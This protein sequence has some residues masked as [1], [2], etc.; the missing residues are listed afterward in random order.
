MPEGTVNSQIV[1]SV[2]NVVTLTGGTAPAQAFAMLDTVMIETLGMAMYNA[3]SRQQ[4]ASMIGSAAVTAACAKMLGTPFG[5]PPPAPPPPE[6]PAPHGVQPLPPRPKSAAEKI[7]EATADA[8]DALKRILE[9]EAAARSNVAAV[10]GA[11][12]QFVEDAG[13]TPTPT[14]A[15]VPPAP[16]PAPAPTPAPAPAPAPAPPPASTLQASPAAEAVAPPS[17]TTTM[18][19]TGPTG[20]SARGVAVTPVPAPPAAPPPAAGAVATHTEL[21]VK[22]DTL[23]VEPGAPA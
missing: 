14:P 16:A 3:V 15:P 21:S 6:P 23:S 2:A 1:D 18:L 12:E 13:G 10:T 7:A 4:G 9:E 20:I 11:L 5:S 17:P 8:E 19:Y 22:T